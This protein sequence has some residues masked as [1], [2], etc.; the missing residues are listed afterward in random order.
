[1]L[2]NLNQHIPVPLKILTRDV[3]NRFKSVH[4]TSE[5]SKV[6]LIPCPNPAIFESGCGITA[7]LLSLPF[8]LKS[9][10][11]LILGADQGLG[12]QMEHPQWFVP[13]HLKPSLALRFPLDQYTRRMIYLVLNV[14]CPV[15]SGTLAAA[16]FDRPPFRSLSTW[17]WKAPTRGP[18]R[19]TTSRRTV[20]G[21]SSWQSLFG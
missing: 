15:A 2:K 18:A 5:T 19:T 7:P 21:R 13:C 10:S 20:P 8:M 12:L 9:K 3:H 4:G 14:I 17:P 11:H 6:A 1:M 16:D